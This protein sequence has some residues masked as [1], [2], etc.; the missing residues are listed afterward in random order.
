MKN[1]SSLTFKDAYMWHRNLPIDKMQLHRSFTANQRKSYKLYYILVFP[2]SHLAFE[3]RKNHCTFLCFLEHIV[4]TK[5][6]RRWIQQQFWMD[7]DSFRK[8]W[9]GFI[10]IWNL[11]KDFPMD[12]MCLKP[13]FFDKVP[14]CFVVGDRSTLLQINSKMLRFLLWT[15]GW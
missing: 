10:C 14:S 7:Q 5:L 12:P 13:L 6:P 3:S 2:I 15:K 4:T 1:N 9:S 11:M 8:G